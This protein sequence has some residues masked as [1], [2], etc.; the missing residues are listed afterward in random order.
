MISHSRSN[1][2]NNN[3]DMMIL[4]LEQPSSSGYVD[5]PLEP[6]QNITRSSSKTPRGRPFGS[7]NKPKP[8]IITNKNT[9]L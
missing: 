6:T 8:H 4:S 7:K 1:N 3:E 2:N 9:N 5:L